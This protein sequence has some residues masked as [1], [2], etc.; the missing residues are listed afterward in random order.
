MI[1]FRNTEAIQAGIS[2]K[3]LRERNKLSRSEFA[4][5]ARLT[6]EYLKCLEEGREDKISE[7]II[8]RILIAGR[9]C[10]RGKKYTSEELKNTLLSI[11][12]AIPP[13]EQ[14]FEL[15]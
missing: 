1:E 13:E 2:I 11:K 6:P 9:V 12:A 15:E 7:E 4:V 8:E 14:L 10:K 3:E 5:K